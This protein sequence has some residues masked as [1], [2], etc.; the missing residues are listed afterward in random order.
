M[1]FL[2]MIH[3]DDDLVA[4]LP[5]GEFDRLM[6]GCFEKADELRAAGKLLDSQQLEHG[7]TARTLRQR[8]GRMSITD[9]PFSEAKEVLAGFNLIEA[10]DMDEAMEIARQFPWSQT[11]HIE[12]RPVRDMDAV[13]DRVG[14]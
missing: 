12:I 14:A 10:A 9:G 7:R 2:V 8:E 6:K 3:T 5:E 13:R 11:G 1:K 4:E